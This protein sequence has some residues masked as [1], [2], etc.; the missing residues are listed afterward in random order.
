MRLLIAYDGSSYAIEAIDDLTHAA[1]PKDTEA[2]VMTV[3]DVFLPPERTSGDALPPVDNL[4]RRARARVARALEDAARFAE[5]GRD[6]V[7]ARFPSWKVEALTCAD[8]P[9]WG[10]IKKR[11]ACA[12][13]KRERRPGSPPRRRQAPV[14]SMR[15]PPLP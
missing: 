7:C 2:V 9:A 10:I 8:S 11:A 1:L 12:R 4:V 14:R 6:H 3:A 13:R 5:T 15:R